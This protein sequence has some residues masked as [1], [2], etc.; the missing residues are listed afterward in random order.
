MFFFFLVESCLLI[1]ICI[2]HRVVFLC[3]LH[4]ALSYLILLSPDPGH[5]YCAQPYATPRQ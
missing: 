4:S 1:L 5:V 2:R 3:F